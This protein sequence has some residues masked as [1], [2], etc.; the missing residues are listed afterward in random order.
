MAVPTHTPI[1]IA[2]A[3]SCTCCAGSHLLA[4]LRPKLLTPP[5][6]QQS[7][8]ASGHLPHHGSGLDCAAQRSH[9]SSVPEAAG[10]G[11]GKALHG[12]QDHG[13]HV[14]CVRL[15]RRFLSFHVFFMICPSVCWT[16]TC[17]FVASAW[18]SNHVA[19]C[20]VCCFGVHVL[21]V[22]LRGGGLMAQ[23]AA[24]RTTKEWIN[25]EHALASGIF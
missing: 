11:V 6:R 21:W 24:T 9:E 5:R 18:K 13:M 1:F 4:H 17:G 20:C 14:M 8:H 15:V 23:G 22:L 12:K 3:H 25:S 2:G 19:R 10:T 7:V 16:W